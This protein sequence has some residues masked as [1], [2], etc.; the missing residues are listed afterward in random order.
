MPMFKS[1]S[2]AV[3]VFSS[4]ALPALASVTVSSPANGAEVTSP[5]TLSASASDCSS[6]SIS[7]LGYSLDSSPDTTI[8][9]GASV[10]AQI[11]AAVGAHTLHVKSWGNQGS[12]CVTDVAI[13]VT[14]TTAPD[15][16]GSSG[17]SVSSPGSGA[18]VS[19]SFPVTASAASCSNESVVAMAYSLD[20]GANAATV[21]GTSLSATASAG[22]GAH[23][24]HVKSWGN[25]GAGC[26]VAIPITVSSSAPGSPGSGSSNGITVTSPANGSVVGTSFSLVADAASCSSQAVV[27]MGYSL[28]SSSGTTIVDKTVVGATIT[29]SAGAHTLHVKSWGDGGAGCDSDVAI[30]AEATNPGT[31]SDGI[32]V[33]TPANGASVS[34]SFNL[35]ASAATCSSQQ[36]NAMGYSLDSSS[37]TVTFNGTSLNASVATSA[38]AHTVHVKSWGN[39][40]AG[41]SA[42]VAITA[43]GSSPTSPTSIIPSYAISVSSIQTLGNWIEANDP[44]NGGSS[45]GSMSLVGSPTLSSDSR[46][47]V[48]H[49]SHAGG[50][51]YYVSFGDDTT[52]TNFFYDAYVYVKSPSSQVANVEMDMNQ[53]MANGQ[54]AIFGFECDGYN[55]TWD[56]TRNSGTPTKP[57]DTWVKSSAYCN[58]RDWS[59]NTWHH[60][61][62]YYSR[63]GTGTI[64]YHTVWLDGAEQSINATV[65]SAFAL[66][67]APTLLTNFQVDGVGSSGSSTIYL[68]QLTIYRW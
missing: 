33:T 66:G 48:T 10:N 64:T 44:G 41:C 7:A 9:N 29:T 57:I 31:S 65:N 25:K 12:S 54:T 63:T 24:L 60:V 62:V 16:T 38:G 52:S 35:E 43:A 46:E 2:V 18:S 26:A 42:D 50:E 61:Q 51:R 45:S 49:Y 13:T 59:T 58:P 40:G 19:T 17:I 22:A 20:N 8:V 15:T 14:A 37:N 21:N 5:F 34:T 23:T 27:A 11:P 55:S 47:F 53:T 36:V 68:D 67:W 56:Y 39:Q 1:V 32:T 30:T 4:F 6:Q 28:D 3:L